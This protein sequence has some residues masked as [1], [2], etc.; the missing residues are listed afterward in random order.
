M[1][2]T[3]KAASAPANAGGHITPPESIQIIQRVLNN[4]GEHLRSHHEEASADCFEA[5]RR[6]DVVAS[7]RADL[8]AALR[9][10]A[11]MYPPATIGHQ[12]SDVARAA[13][14]D[15]ERGDK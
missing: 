3:I 15:A 10:I 12:A 6:L 5:A 2:N 7:E 9:K 14:A 8:L 11:D 4:A 13:I 1:K